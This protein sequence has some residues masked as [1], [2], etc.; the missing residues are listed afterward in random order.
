M[1]IQKP[2]LILNG[3]LLVM[4]IT[5]WIFLVQR[6]AQSP[7]SPAAIAEIL[8]VRLFP[9]VSNPQ[10][11]IDSVSGEKTRVLP[12]FAPGEKMYFGEAEAKQVNQTLQFIQN[13]NLS[14]ATSETSDWRRFGEFRFSGPGNKE[15]TVVPLYRAGEDRIGFE[16]LSNRFVSS[17]PLPTELWQV[18]L[19][20]G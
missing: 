12:T 8:G 4:A 18:F 10:V 19:P 17:A 6:R 20:P 7:P 5:A 1:T 16:W 3:L 13:L 9:N 15:P 2:H 14:Q 11:W